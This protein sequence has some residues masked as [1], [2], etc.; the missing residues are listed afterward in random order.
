[1]TMTGF[2]YDPN[3]L[4]VSEE[5]FKYLH[6]LLENLVVFFMFILGTISVLVW[7][8]LGFAKSKKAFW[9]AWAWAFSVVFSVLMLAG[10]FNTPFYPSLTDL[11]HSLTIQNASS[12][13]YSLTV[14]SYVS[15][16]IP[17]VLAYIIWAW[18]AIAWKPMT[19]E[20]IKDELETY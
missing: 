2:S 9:L 15:L 4:K 8:W 3:T 16:I 20:N 5:N 18:H 7:I 1:M 12:S 11:Q 10:L 14:M 6:N 19:R 17:F 13:Q